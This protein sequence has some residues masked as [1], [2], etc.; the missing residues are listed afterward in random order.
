MHI[1]SK[2]NF[3]ALVHWKLYFQGNWLIFLPGFSPIKNSESFSI[4]HK[5]K[6]SL[7]LIQFIGT[8]NPLLQIIFDVPNYR[9]FY[10]Y[11]L[12]MLYIQQ[13]LEITKSILEFFKVSYWFMKC[14]T[15]EN[16]EKL[17]N[18]FGDFQCVLYAQHV[19]LPVIYLWQVVLNLKT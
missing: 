18:G 2:N 5:F 19:K 1:F 10:Q 17:Q 7:W 15:S 16:Y 13:T 3:I 8:G 9:K 4:V 11:I 12:N 6:M 14:L